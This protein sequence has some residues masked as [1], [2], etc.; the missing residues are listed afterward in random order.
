MM[1]YLFF[2]VGIALCWITSASAIEMDE[3][4]AFIDVTSERVAAR[5]M[6]PIMK[7]TK[8]RLVCCFNGRVLGPEVEMLIPVPFAIVE[9]ELRALLKSRFG[10]K[11]YTRLFMQ[12][13]YKTINFSQHSDE[14]RKQLFASE[15]AD[16]FKVK[17]R[18]STEYYEQLRAQG[19]ERYADFIIK[20]EIK[21]RAFTLKYNRKRHE[22]ISKEREAG[23]NSEVFHH[24]QIESEPYHIGIGHDKNRST[25]TVH[26]I[27]AR[28]VFGVDGTIVTLHRDD[29]NY[30]FGV[31]HGLAIGTF[32]WGGGA[33][34]EPEF[35]LLLDLERKTGVSGLVTQLG[36]VTQ[37]YHVG[38]PNVDVTLKTQSWLFNHLSSGKAEK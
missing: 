35:Q 17:D 4:L 25:L 12:D 16:E 15:I 5:K 18:V 7:Q 34:T 29:D 20:D 37:Y 8:E 32:N 33:I 31:G 30:S 9:K 36:L 14:L 13:N 28:E 10:E 3:Q 19:Q 23:I 22:R 21:D 24:V 2:S 6:T 11:S 38:S 26:L 1:R 27:D